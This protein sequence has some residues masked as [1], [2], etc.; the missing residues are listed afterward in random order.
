ML[1]EV[2]EDGTKQQLLRNAYAV[3]NLS[4]SLDESFGKSAAESLQAGTPVLGTAWA[5]FPETIGPGGALAPV[6][7]KRDVPDVDADVVAQR[8]TQL[9]ASPPTPETCFEHGR[10]FSRG[11]VSLRYQDELLRAL[12]TQ[13]HPDDLP[14]VSDQM[15]SVAPHGGVLANLGVLGRMTWRHVQDLHLRECRRLYNQLFGGWI[16]A[17]D[18]SDTMRLRRIIRRSA[19]FDTSRLLMGHI[20]ASRQHCGNLSSWQGEEAF[21]M[22]PR[23]DLMSAVSAT[24]AAWGPSD[25]SRVPALRELTDS[26]HASEGHFA[27]QNLAAHS[28]G[29]DAEEAYLENAL[30]QAA[31]SEVLEYCKSLCNCETVEEWPAYRVRSIAAASVHC[32]R[33]DVAIEALTCWLGCYPDEPES[34]QVWLDLA[35]CLALEGSRPVELA[36]CIAS[37]RRFLGPRNIYLN[38]LMALVGCG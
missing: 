32:T 18:V 17:S 25:H 38:R 13:C 33:T 6:V 26:G 12:S 20:P 36:Q 11:R 31:F 8:L 7:M 27:S 37:A 1:G 29:R 10:Q 5:A 30:A 14:N 21:F 22:R 3:I 28:T 34:P 24:V 2:V 23:I 19:Q 15:G 16:R 4:V 9:L 35:I